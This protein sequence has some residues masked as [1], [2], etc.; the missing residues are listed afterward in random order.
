M[1][2]T[3]SLCPLAGADFV[4]TSPFGRRRSPFTQELDFHPGLDLAAPR[5]TAI[6]APADG[7]VVFAGRYPLA[8]SV[9]WWRYG[10]LVVLK[11]GER[12]LTL[13]G[14]CEEVRVRT[15]ERVR[16]GD[17]LATVGSTGWS[18]NPHLHYEVRRREDVGDFLALDPRIYILDR[19]WRDEERLLVQARSAA[20]AAEVQPL[21]TL[22]TR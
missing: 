11:H 7:V 19:R 18:T 15:G 2:T 1:R 16:Q 8:A 17:L 6:T 10:N 20:P 14:H 5:G 9:G 13:Y 12:F 22:F 21:P 4:L 3:P